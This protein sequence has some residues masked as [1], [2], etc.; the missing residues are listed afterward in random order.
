MN[1]T[2]PENVQKNTVERLIKE[3]KEFCAKERLPMFAT[4]YLP[5][6]DTYISDIVSPKILGIEIEPDRITEHLNVANG[7][8][9]VPPKEKLLKLNSDGTIVDDDMDENDEALMAA[10]ECAK[11]E[12]ELNKELNNSE[13]DSE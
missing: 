5:S 1:I 11:S 7:F 4:V 10:K 3:L 8:H 12:E 9:T 2:A 6:R 13:D